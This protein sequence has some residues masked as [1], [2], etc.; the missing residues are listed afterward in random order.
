MN[1]S[2]IGI[3][4]IVNDYMWCLQI[5][6]VPTF[7][8]HQMQNGTIA[9]RILLNFT[10]TPSLTISNTVLYQ[11][12]YVKRLIWYQDFV[13]LKMQGKKVTR[14]SQ[15]SLFPSFDITPL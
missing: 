8:M 13:L 6:L 15:L 9:M 12:F 14:P 2:I 4:L 1:K 3:L 5:T 11:M 10:E 7:V